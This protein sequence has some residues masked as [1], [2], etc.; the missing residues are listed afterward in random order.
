VN[1][2]TQSVRIDVEPEHVY[3]YVSDAQ[4]LPQWATGFAKSVRAQGA[5]TW[6]VETPQGEVELQVTADPHHGVIDFWIEPAP[7]I[8]V[9]AASRVVGYG[10]ITEFM[11]TQFQPPG[12]PD[13]LFQS[14]VDA[15][16]TE[17]DGLK[18][19]LESRE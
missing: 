8:R 9:L 2:Q 12:M 3:G 17:L 7:G 5:G 16:R 6:N 1:S 15:A 13:A 14:Q 19:R 10:G 4:N 11:F 18:A